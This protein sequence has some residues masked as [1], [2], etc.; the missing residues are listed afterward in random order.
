MTNRGKASGG[1]VG[2]LRRRV[3]AGERRPYYLLHGEEDY[4]CE[5]TA[6]WLIE[7]V[8]PD[9]AVDFN[10]DVFHGDELEPMA[11]VQAYNAF[12]VMSTHRLVVVKAI[13]RLAAADLARL[14][15]IFDKP[16]ETT[17]FVA[18]GGKIDK[19]RKFFQQLAKHTVL[20]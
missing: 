17:I 18:T 5:T 10:V 12:P 6:K 9:V 11:V 14:E 20:V 15:E 19:R 1:E 8:K 16:A 4:E 7:Q 13:H 2:D 3:A